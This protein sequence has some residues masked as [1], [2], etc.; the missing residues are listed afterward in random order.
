MAEFSFYHL[1]NAPLDRAL[2]RL[3]ERVVERGLHAVV[4]AGSN[5]RVEFLNALLWTY[6]PGSFLPHGS[7]ADGDTGEQPIYLTTKEENPNQATVLVL[8]DGGGVDFAKGFDRCL[9]V[10]DGNDPAAVAGARE[11]WK[12]A[13]A[14]G[15]E[16]TYWQQSEQGRWEKVA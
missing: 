12:V 9:D 8:V 4:L 13:R 3:L 5:E 15:F 14:A 2:P 6:D 7:D 10:F 11:R 16:V 1:Q